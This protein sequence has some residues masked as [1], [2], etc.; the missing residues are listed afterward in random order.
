MH[1]V[2]ARGHW[3][4]YISI[5]GQLGFVFRIDL[6]RGSDCWPIAKRC[7]PWSLAR[8]IPSSCHL[9]FVL[10]MDLLFNCKALPIIVPWFVY[11]E[12]ACQMVLYFG[13]WFTSGSYMFPRLAMCFLYFGWVIAKR[14]SNM[15]VGP[16]L[17]QF[18]A[19]WGFAFRQFLAKCLFFGLPCAWPRLLV[20]CK[21]L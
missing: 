15:V 16:Y 9:G 19:K 10:R 1:A 7:P 11:V 21:A 2:S 3:L 20:H 13:H 18:P 5:S 17:C 8:L 4:V 12:V 14:L 6:R